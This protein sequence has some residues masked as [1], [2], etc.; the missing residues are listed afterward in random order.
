[1]ANLAVGQ[2]FV[3]NLNAGDKT[4]FLVD[5]SS[6]KY[7]F[8]CG[9]SANVVVGVWDKDVE[10]NGLVRISGVAKWGTRI[11]PTAGAHLITVKAVT[12]GT[13]TF[14]ASEYS[15]FDEI[16]LKFTHKSG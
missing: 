11:V 16:G 12:S 1:M 14:V 10:V 8:K 3:A 13:F 7:T 4:S 9:G 5:L 2:Q 6:K 15:Y